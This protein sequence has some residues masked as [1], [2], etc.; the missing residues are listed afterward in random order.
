[1]LFFGGNNEVIYTQ[2]DKATF[3]S[4]VT[5]QEFLFQ[6]KVMLTI[7]LLQLHNKD[8]SMKGFEYFC[9]SRYPSEPKEPGL[10]T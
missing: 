2:Y 3:D 1:M 8:G 5:C 9:E 7:E 4:N 10:D 6:N